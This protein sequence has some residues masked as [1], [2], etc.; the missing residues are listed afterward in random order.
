VMGGYGTPSIR[1]K[2]FG[3]VTQALLG[4]MTVPVVMSH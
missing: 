2:I 3:G 4:S 1:Q